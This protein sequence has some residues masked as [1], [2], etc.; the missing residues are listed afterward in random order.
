MQPPRPEKLGQ[1]ESPAVG[2]WTSLN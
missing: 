2:V 1:A